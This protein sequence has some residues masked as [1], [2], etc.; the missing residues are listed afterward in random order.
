[1]GLLVTLTELLRR[2]TILTPLL[3]RY[4]SGHRAATSAQSLENMEQT[5]TELRTAHIEAS[6]TLQSA[7]RELH[8]RQ[9]KVEDTLDR[10][11]SRLTEMSNHRED[12]FKQL[13]KWMKA[14]AGVGLALLVA[15]LAAI[16]LLLSR[17]R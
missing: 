3:E 8:D 5:V 9:G 12:E 10:V 6:S 15:V 4:V 14:V 16:G 2:L 17:M 13:N 7:L 1:M 11:A